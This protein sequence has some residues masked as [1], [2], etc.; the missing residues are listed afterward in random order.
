MNLLRITDIANVLRIKLR[1]MRAAKD[2][3]LD[4]LIPV[5]QALRKNILTFIMTVTYDIRVQS[6][7]IIIIP[8]TPL[9]SFGDNRL[10]ESIF[11]QNHSTL[12]IRNTLGLDGHRSWKRRQA[13]IKRTD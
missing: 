2:K 9:P 5:E 13:N 1:D 11:E 4:L 7:I 3:Y 6:S 12:N 8:I 10:I